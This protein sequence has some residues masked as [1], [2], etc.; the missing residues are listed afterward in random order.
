M[1]VAVTGASGFVGGHVA[2]ALA[3]CGH[4]VFS[5]GQRPAASLTRRLPNYTAWDV[6]AGPI[7]RPSV[8]AVVHSAAL[9]GD[10]GPEAAYRAVNV[11]GTRFVL[12]S[13]A[14]APRFVHVSTTSVYS[15]DVVKHHVAE[16]ASTGNCA[17]SAYGRTKAESERVVRERK[18][19]AVILR[20][21]IVYGPG[22]TTLLPRLLAARRFGCLAVPGDGRNRLSVTHVDNLVL[23][24]MRAM[25]ATDASGTFN[26]ADGEEATVRELLQTIMTRLGAPTRLVFVPGALAWHAAA[27]LE[28]A[29]PR[30]TGT[31]GPPLTR[32]AVGQLA[33]EHTLDITRARTLLEY[34]PRW[35]YRDGPLGV[36]ARERTQ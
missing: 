36:V 7:S 23:A 4:T 10:W 24:V 12:E 3:R 22:D 27:M 15:D 31:S 18:P 21:H 2:T 9:V 14:D 33:A 6:S 5:Y 32:Y 16:D 29:W 19:D 28:H 30:G 20:P 25:E 35:S 34:E 26:I 1:R 17:H 13:F 8:D 11:D